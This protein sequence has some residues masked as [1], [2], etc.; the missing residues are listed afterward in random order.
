MNET[1]A[2]SC[3]PLCE[4][5]SFNLS[6]LRYRL[7]YEIM[8]YITIV[9]KLIISD[10]LTNYDHKNMSCKWKGLCSVRAIIYFH[11]V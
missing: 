7:F 11:N 2:G 10:D 5:S 3:I 8:Q 4:I 1:V 9:T 6:I